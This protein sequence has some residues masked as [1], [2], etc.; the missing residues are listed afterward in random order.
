VLAAFFLASRR[1]TMLI[2][3]RQ[4]TAA[5]RRALGASELREEYEAAQVLAVCGGWQ[6]IPPL[7]SGVYVLLIGN[8]IP[9]SGL[10][11]PI[12]F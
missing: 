8:R 12:F 4:E 6:V 1:T 3:P 2:S 11:Y 7:A 5:L 10:H 9:W